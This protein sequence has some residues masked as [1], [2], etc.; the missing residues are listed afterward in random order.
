MLAPNDPKEHAMTERKVHTVKARRRI[1]TGIVS[2]AV[3][4]VLA[5]AG[6]G[7][8][9]LAASSVAGRGDVP[10]PP[11]SWQSPGLLEPGSLQPG[12]PDPL[13][14]TRPLNSEPAEPSPDQPSAPSGPRTLRFGMEGSDVEGLQRRLNDLGYTIALVDG[15]FGQETHHAVVAFQK[16]NGLTR[17]GIVGPRSRRALDR[18]LRLTPHSK[19]AGLHVEVDLVRQVL[20]L[21]EDGRVGEIYDTSTGSGETYYVDGDAR[22]ARTPIGTFAIERKIDGWR[23]STLGTLYRPA[24]F[25]GGYAIHGSPSVPPYPASH[26]CVRLTNQVMDRLF[27]RLAYGVTVIVYAG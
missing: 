15:V 23:E 25:Y 21:V 6:A 8:S 9:R 17:D 14:R 26:G 11:T 13:P 3:L 4:A 20:V 22:I 1:R 16:V 12:S 19:A 2:V 27:D 24:Y 18:P 5:G 10:A 7:A